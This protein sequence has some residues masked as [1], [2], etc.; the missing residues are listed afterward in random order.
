MNRI[1]E[2]F[3]YLRHR[4]RR[5]FIPFI[6][7]GDPHLRTT[8]RLVLALAEAGAD[9]IELGMPF[10]D[11][12]ADGP[13]LQRAA[14]RALDAGTTPR[15]VLVLV[16][17]LRQRTSIPLVALSYVNPIIR[18]SQRAHQA[19]RDVMRSARLG[20]RH[21]LDAASTAGL[22]GVIVPDLPPEEANDWTQQARRRGVATILLAAPTSSTARLRLI[23][24]LASGF[25]YYVSL[26][27]TTGVRER[28]ASDVAQGVARVRAWTTLPICVGFGISTPA[29]AH[30]VARVADGVIVGSALVRAQAQA[31]TPRG[32]VAAVVRLARQLRGAI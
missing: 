13:T 32:G 18:F 26:T 23:T 24:R 28:L 8:E 3:A 6:M 10:S 5:A 1:T 17:R 12:L 7:A 9:I 2:V 15:S 4:R 19:R 20:M 16:E 11:P 21:F 29:Q 31:R 22:D 25:L 30:D 27:G 14:R